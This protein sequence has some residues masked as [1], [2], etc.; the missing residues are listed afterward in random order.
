VATTGVKIAPEKSKIVEGPF[1]FLGFTIDLK[2]RI[3]EREDLGL[4]KYKD[5]PEDEI[6]QWIRRGKGIYSN[7]SSINTK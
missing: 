4:L 2:K 5:L 7:P 3:I 1:K 6:I